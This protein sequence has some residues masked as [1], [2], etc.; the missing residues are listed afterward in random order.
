[1]SR[2]AR[3]NIS[4]DVKES[5][6]NDYF[7]NSIVESEFLDSLKEA[8]ADEPP[9]GMPQNAA[10][11]AEMMP[12]PQQAVPMNPGM[13][14]GMDPSMGMDPGMDPGMGGMGGMGGFGMPE[15]KDV[16]STPTNIGRLFEIQ[17]IYT[18]LKALDGIIIK[19]TDGD[20]KRLKKLVGDAIEVF[21][22]VISNLKVYRDRLDKII[23]YF[24]KFI[25][26]L[27]QIVQ[28]YYEKKNSTYK[29]DKN[30]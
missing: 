25:Y 19:N 17:K 8:G 21:D 11:P 14:G 4:S 15:E 9:Q 13:M 20:L 16:I 6:R 1:M 3:L 23:I 26:R 30:E 12:A 5:L 2:Y 22:L 27:T 18:Y 28:L 24:Y 7:M 10:P 29:K